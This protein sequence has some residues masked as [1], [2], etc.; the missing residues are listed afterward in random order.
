VFYVVAF[1]P[2]QIQA[3]WA[4]QNDHLK[5]NFVKDINVVGKKMTRKGHKMGNI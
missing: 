1:D 4:H 2:N 5:L 3:C